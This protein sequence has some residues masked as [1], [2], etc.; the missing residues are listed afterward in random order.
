MQAIQRVLLLGALIR[1]AAALLVADGSHCATQCGNVLDATTD[2]DIACTDG[3]YAGTS[4]GTVFR[5][6]LTCE[7]ASTYSDPQSLPA[8]SDLQSMLYN[9]RYA[10][11][12]CLFQGDVNPCITGTACEPL[13]AAIEYQDLAPNVTTYGYCSS[14]NHDIVP[15]CSSCLVN[16]EGGKLLNNCTCAHPNVCTHTLT[17]ARLANS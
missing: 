4:A 11:S 15:R 17:A 6:C 14:W 8:A 9:L 5:N 13:K 16:L 2:A 10:T 12:Q 3:E 1:P 7:V